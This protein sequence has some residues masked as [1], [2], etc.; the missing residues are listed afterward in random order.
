MSHKRK[1]EE[2]S[3]DWFVS[4][5]IKDLE[6]N[7]F[8]I[9]EGHLLAH[10]QMTIKGRK[11][12][13]VKFR[14]PS[15]G[16]EIFHEA[17]KRHPDVWDACVFPVIDAPERPACDYP[18]SVHFCVTTPSVSLC[19]AGL[20]GEILL[21]IEAFLA[22]DLCA[23]VLQYLDPV[24]D[25]CPLIEGT[26]SYVS[27][28]LVPVGLMLRIDRVTEWAMLVSLN[29]KQRFWCNAQLLRLSFTSIQIPPEVR[30]VCSNVPCEA[31][32]PFFGFVLVEQLTGSIV[33][34]MDR[35]SYVDDRKVES[36][37]KSIASDRS[38]LPRTR[39]ELSVMFGKVDPYTVTTGRPLLPEEQNAWRALAAMNGSFLFLTCL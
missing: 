17:R 32:G 20:P 39:H 3:W 13:R 21:E 29:N 14:S 4:H 22:K 37:A 15:S 2:D 12:C 34:S 33:A 16:Y 10:I 36:Q 9:R 30:K 35:I 1:Y 7:K 23:I 5:D 8:S 31:G 26:P 11:T 18:L 38:C 25:E 6:C 28:F 27:P 24:R 19:R